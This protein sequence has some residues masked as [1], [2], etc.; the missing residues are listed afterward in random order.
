MTFL[1]RLTRFS[2]LRILLVVAA[3]WLAMWVYSGDFISGA[4]ISTVLMYLFGYAIMA[5]GM[6]VL[7]VSGGF[8][9]S[10]GSVSALAAMTTAVLMK[11]PSLH[12][13]WP[14]ALLTGGGTIKSGKGQPLY[15]FGGNVNPGCSPT[16]GEGGNWNL[17][18]FTQN[19]H[20]QATAI[21]VLD[22]GNVEGVNGST[23]PATPF[24]F[25]D[26]EGSGVVK[27]VQGNKIVTTP[28][29]F[30]A[31]YE[32]LGEPGGNVD[33]LFLTAFDTSGTP[34]LVIGTETDPVLISTGN[35]QLHISS[36]P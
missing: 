36:C 8:D 29:T 9:L 31:H 16:A 26:W 18:D 1:N 17:I 12:L 32:D 21:T 4:T 5:C 27:G 11:D 20:F 23:S 22:C 15:S 10:V 6:T 35:L 13:A 28:V 30:F 33:R 34:V 14:I 7:L 24:S 19:L 25:I 2:E 3:F